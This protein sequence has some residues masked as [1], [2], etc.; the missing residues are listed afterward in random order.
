ML[1]VIERRL[2]ARIILILGTI[3][4]NNSDK[5]EQDVSVYM[6]SPLLSPPP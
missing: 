6:H 1:I 5:N 2:H 4:V 3:T